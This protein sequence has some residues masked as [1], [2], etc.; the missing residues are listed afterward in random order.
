MREWKGH[1]GTLMPF[2]KCALPV[3]GLPCMIHEG[4]R[5][6]LSIPCQQCTA[7]LPGAVRQQS[8]S[9]AAWSHSS[10]NDS[11]QPCSLLMHHLW[12]LPCTGC[13]STGLP[14]RP[15]PAQTPT[16]PCEGASYGGTSSR[17]RGHAA[18]KGGMGTSLDPYAGHARRWAILQSQCQHQARCLFPPQMSTSGHVVAGPWR[19]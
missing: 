18:H 6:W 13:P 14:H 9:L 3:T 16:S 1:C 10:V 12:Q 15:K 17:K 5:S 7:C 19:T 2:L 4:L 8:M 11:V